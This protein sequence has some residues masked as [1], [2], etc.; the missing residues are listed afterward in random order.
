MRKTIKEIYEG[1]KRSGIEPVRCP[2]DSQIAARTSGP[3]LRTSEDDFNKIKFAIFGAF[4]P[5]YFVRTYTG[6]ET[7]E[8]IKELNGA[9]PMSSV[10]LHVAT[11]PQS[12]LHCLPIYE[13]QIKEFFKDQGIAMDLIKVD[14]DGRKAIVSFDRKDLNN[15]TMISEVDT[16]F[17]EQLS[18]MEI[19]HEVGLQFL[20]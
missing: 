5:N 8:I 15:T 10:A 1:L 3:R 11:F 7:K 2:N 12:Q 13:V 18:S 6:W 17:S 19:L 20:S 9:D 4:Y 16:T 14:F